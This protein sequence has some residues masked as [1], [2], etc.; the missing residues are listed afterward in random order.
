[1]IGIAQNRDGKAKHGEA[2]KRKR[3]ATQRTVTEPKS[4]DTQRNGTE[5]LRQDPKRN[6]NALTDWQRNGKAKI[7]RRTESGRKEENM[8]KFKVGDRVELISNIHFTHACI[9]DKGKVVSAY[10]NV[11]GD[12]CYGVQ[13]DVKRP[14]YHSCHGK[15]AVG[16]GQYLWG[17]CL[18]LVEEKP[19]REFKLI[20]TSS[21]DTTTAK[22][23]HGE[24]TVVKEAT[25]TRYSKDEYSEKAAVKAVVKKI[26]GEDEKKNEANKPYTGKAVWICDNESVYT[27]G[28]IYEFV[29]GKFKHDLG[30]TVVGYTLEKMKRLG[31]FLP[32]VE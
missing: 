2:W 24:R 27:K 14:F 18:K 16:Y 30:F 29:D 25:V 1:M 13:M 4:D 28:K 23:I 19:T 17:S 10:Y 26:F 12:T 5:S 8:A 3:K 22:L 9:G 21:G 11:V 7:S 32:I 20:I 15:A 31:C 6:R